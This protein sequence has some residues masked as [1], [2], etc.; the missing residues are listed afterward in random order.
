[1]VYGKERTVEVGK[2]LNVWKQEVGV[3]KIQ[4]DIWNTNAPAAPDD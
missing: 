1:M 2:Y 3:W 4:S